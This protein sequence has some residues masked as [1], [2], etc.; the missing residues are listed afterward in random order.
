MISNVYATFVNTFKDKIYSL[1]ENIQKLRLDQE[2]HLIRDGTFLF[3]LLQQSG[4]DLKNNPDLLSTGLSIVMFNN[5]VNNEAKASSISKIFDGLKL[6]NRFNEGEIQNCYKVNIQ[7]DNN[8]RRGQ[9]RKIQEENKRPTRR[10][11][12]WCFDP[13]LAMGLLEESGVRNII[14]TSGT[15]SPLNSLET[16]LSM[17]A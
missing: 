4:L 7:L 11:C 13:G 9:H 14:I 15:L 8:N 17:Y 5:K 1:V 16:E 12:F 6:A 2:G 3:N 10:V